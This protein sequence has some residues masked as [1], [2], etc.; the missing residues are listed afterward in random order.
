[1]HRKADI[2]KVNSFART[3]FSLIHFC[4]EL[5]AKITIKTYNVEK[6]TLTKGTKIWKS[7]C[8]YSFAIKTKKVSHILDHFV[9][10]CDSVSVSFRNSAG[11]QVIGSWGLKGQ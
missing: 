5:W 6:K 3:I 1:M 4:A 8:F 10:M 11:G 2:L 9:R 7:A